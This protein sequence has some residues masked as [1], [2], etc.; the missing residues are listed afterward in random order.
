MGL[1]WLL[2]QGP[3]K[4]VSEAGAAPLGLLYYVHVEST[5]REGFCLSS[6]LL[7]V[8][9]ESQVQEAMFPTLMMGLSVT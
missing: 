8:Q 3:F 6:F 1:F 7:F 4:E 2:V 9:F 5:A